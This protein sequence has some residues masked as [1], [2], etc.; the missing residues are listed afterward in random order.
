MSG[1][2][3]TS[4]A[5]GSVRASRWPISSVSDHDQRQRIPPTAPGMTPGGRT[6]TLMMD[7]SN[8]GPMSRALKEKSQGS[9]CKASTGN[10]PTPSSGYRNNQHVVEA[11]MIGLPMRKSRARA[12]CGTV[13]PR[14]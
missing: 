13:T 7:P 2:R 10:S 11:Y 9:Y 1:T 5:S 6:P 8:H 3:S 12:S 14:R 4:S